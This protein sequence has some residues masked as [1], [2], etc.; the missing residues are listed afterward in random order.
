[1]G[2]VERTYPSVNGTFR[3]IGE[4][5]HPQRTQVYHVVRTM[6]RL[7]VNLNLI[8]ASLNLRRW[9]TFYGDNDWSQEDVK[10]LIA[11]SCPESEG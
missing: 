6:N 10:E 4:K 2:T 7:G 3:I 1:M 5:Y 11:N 8:A 9:K